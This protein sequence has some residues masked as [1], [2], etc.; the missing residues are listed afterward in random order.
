MAQDQA[1]PLVGLTAA[2]VHSLMEGTTD[3]LQVITGGD[4]GELHWVPFASPSLSG[5][6]RT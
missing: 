4:C 5:M 6:I 1:P 3:T 2:M